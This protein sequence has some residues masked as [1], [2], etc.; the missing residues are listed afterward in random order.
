[1]RPSDDQPFPLATVSPPVRP[2]GSIRAHDFKLPKPYRKKRFVEDDLAPS[3]ARIVFLGLSCVMVAGLVTTLAWL[4][5]ENRDTPPV[6]VVAAPRV[7]P[8]VAAVRLPAPVVAPLPEAPAPVPV[9]ETI[10]LAAPPAPSPSPFVH[11][12]VARLPPPVKPAQA[13]RPAP[14]IEPPDPDV[15]LIA[16]I[17]SLTPPQPPAPLSCVPGRELACP[18]IGTMKP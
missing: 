2:R 11:R 14:K 5:Q 17:L 1:M 4:A 13:A 3:K 16:A 6:V 10:V 8:P 12:T 9:P 15:V 7:L 18:T